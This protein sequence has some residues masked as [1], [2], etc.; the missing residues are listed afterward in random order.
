M[1]GLLNKANTLVQ[2]SQFTDV[3]VPA[4]P[5]VT[6]DMAKNWVGA[7]DDDS[8]NSEI[9]LA[10]LAA[11]IKIREL[12]NIILSQ[13][14]VIDHY[15]ANDARFLELAYDCSAQSDISSLRYLDKDNQVQTVDVNN[16]L[17]DTSVPKPRIALKKEL[18]LSN[19]SISEY[20]TNPVY[21]TYTSGLADLTTNPGK[22]QGSNL[23]AM[24]AEMLVDAY[25]NSKGENMDHITKIEMAVGRLLKNFRLGIG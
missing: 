8:D 12:G 5:V 17:L 15:K 22:I 24:A 9:N 1:A 18:I 10:I 13:T 23:L 11:E 20:I 16:Y 19:L 21:I 25:Y 2:K 4:N 3:G 7:F 6:L 14:T